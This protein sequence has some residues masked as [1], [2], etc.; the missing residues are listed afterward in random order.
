MFLIIMN[1]LKGNFFLL[2]IYVLPNSRK[3]YVLE[4]RIQIIL[5]LPRA[6]Q[7]AKIQGTLLRLLS[8]LTP[9]ASL[10]VSHKHAHIQ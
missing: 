9:S 2:Q 1:R 5:C 8:L 6:G 3:L 4:L 7:N 10:G